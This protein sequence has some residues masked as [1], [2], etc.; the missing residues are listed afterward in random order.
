M[1]PCSGQY[2]LLFERDCIMAGWKQYIFSLIVCAFSCAVVSQMISDPKRKALI[3]LICGI[4]LTISILRPFSQMR[5]EDLF[6]IPFLDQNAADLCIAD[7]EET[8]AEARAEYIKASC[9]AYI[10]DKA[11]ALG[12]EI[13]VQFLLEGNQIPAFAEIEGAFT[14]D[15]QMQLQNILTE[16][17]GIPKE[18]QKWIWNQ[19][20]KSS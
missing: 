1:Y 8:A 16:D 5:L 20:S 6:Q 19:E 9:E 17:L 4:I 11:K 15:V 18:N 3:R 14:P 2:G 12:A 10:L 13:T 7:G